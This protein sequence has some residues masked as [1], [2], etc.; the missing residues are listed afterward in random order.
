MLEGLFVLLQRMKQTLHLHLLGVKNL[1]P[2]VKMTTLYSPG[3]VSSAELP[4]NHVS[5]HLK[6]RQSETQFPQMDSQ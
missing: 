5:M 1:M 4:E 3:V 2:R 6:G